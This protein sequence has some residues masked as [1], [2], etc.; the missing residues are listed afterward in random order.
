M[1]EH[2]EERVMPITAALYGKK[3]P[4]RKPEREYVPR[5]ADTPLWKRVTQR[6]LDELAEWFPGRARRLAARRRA[7]EA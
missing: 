7:E 4:R 2:I 3:R 6:E 1:S 5:S